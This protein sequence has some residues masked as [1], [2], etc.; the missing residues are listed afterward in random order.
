MKIFIFFLL[1]LSV[2]SLLNFYIIKRYVNKINFDNKIKSYIKLFLAFNFIGIIFYIIGR[3]SYD[4][5]NWLYYMFSIPIGILFLFFCVVLFYDILKTVLSYTKFS[6][7]RRDAIKRLLDISVPLSVGVVSLKSMYE[8]LHI[9]IKDIDINIKKLKQEYKIIQ[10]SDM[11]IGG[12]IDAQYI[13]EIVKKV[14]ILNPDI[15]VITGDLVDT[16]VSKAKEALDQ[17]KYLKTKHG[18]YFIVGNHEYFHN[19]LK[20]IDTVK[21][22]GIKVLENE[23]IYIGSKNHGFNLAGVY[24]VMGY[25]VDMLQPDIYKALKDLD[26]DSPTILLAHQ[27]RFVDYFDN[28]VDL[29]L[30]GHTH[31]GQIYPFRFLVKLQQPYVSGLYQHNK[32]LQVYVNKGTGFWGPPMR[33]GVSSEITNITLKPV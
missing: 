23:N 14:N 27:P 21:E 8:A 20:I 33:L 4:F 2:F 3:Y 7:K 18:V 16:D 13:K 5:P 1:F 17:L 29:M 11:H 10:L 26:K 25:R 15:V 9:E 31:G 30:S 28:G 6:P 32:K 12:L 24:D 22:L 19:V